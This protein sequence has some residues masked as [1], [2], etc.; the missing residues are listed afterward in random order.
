[1][2]LQDKLVEILTQIQSG[3]KAAGDFAMEQLPDIA[4]SY[5]L[6]GRTLYTSAVL[7]CIVVCAV[8]LWRYKYNEK[9]PKLDDYFKTRT[10][11]QSLVMFAYAATGAI[12]LIL[13]GVAAKSALLVW[14][15]PNVWLL[16]EIAGLIK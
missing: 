10:D 2:N 13:G 4:Q 11:F 9:N 6:Y 14:F 12:F 3:V 7:A 8:C 15:A 16:K 5:V 1:M